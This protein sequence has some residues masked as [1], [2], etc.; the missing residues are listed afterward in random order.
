MAATIDVL[1]RAGLRNHDSMIQGVNDFDL[2]ADAVGKPTDKLT[3][4]MIPAFNAFGIAADQTGPYVDRLAFA[5]NT[6]NVPVDEFSRVM[7]RMGPELAAAGVGI[8]DV[9]T[10]LVLLKDHGYEGRNAMLQSMGISRAEFE[11]QSR[12]LDVNSEGY[13]RQAAQ[14]RNENIPINDRYNTSLDNTVLGM[15]AL[16]SPLTSASS[17]FSTLGS[18]IASIG[19]PLAVLLKGTA[20]GEAILTSIGE[21]ATSIGGSVTSAGTAIGGS[22]A[23]SIG[24]GLAAGLAGVWVLQKT[25]IMDSIADLG[26]TIESS[27]IGGKIMD[28]LKIALLP[29]GALGTVINDAVAGN[30]DRI[31]PD[32]QKVWAQAE[33]AA[34]NFGNTMRTSLGGMD[35]S[36]SLSSIQRLFSGIGAA[37]NAMAGQIRGVFSQIVSAILGIFTSV[38]SGFYAAGMNIITSLVNGIIAA[39]GGIVTAIGGA[40]SKVRALFPFSPAKEGPLAEEPNWGSYMS[41]TMAKAGPQVAQAAATNLAAPAAAGIKAGAGGAGGGSSGGGDTF[42]ITVNGADKDPKSIAM[43]VYQY[44]QAE[45]TAKRKQRGGAYA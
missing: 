31:I 33:Q 3:A 9:S 23:A 30:F 44:I 29:L 43:E 41:G 6:T 13:A 20:F 21:A 4:Q 7:A 12:A 8:D 14:I 40:L 18:S 1:A 38:Q 26:R 10:M 28:S 25:G 15:G 42:N 11:A 22:L 16:T 39:S 36:G 34:R 5:F 37:F 17:L 24:V 19:L 32:L 45:Q 2:L 27:N 35:F